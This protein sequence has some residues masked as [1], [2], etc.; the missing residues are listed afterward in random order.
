M[1]AYDHDPQCRCDRCSLP[2]G[3]AW[4]HCKDHIIDPATQAQCKTCD[5]LDAAP[6]LCMACQKRAAGE[7]GVCEP[8]F[9]VSEYEALLADRMRKRGKR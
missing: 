8:C 2:S 9:R 1:A 5:R 6:T 7:S 3:R 4:C